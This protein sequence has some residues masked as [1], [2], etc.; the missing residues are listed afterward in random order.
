MDLTT[1]ATECWSAPSFQRV[2]GRGDIGT[3]PS[4]DDNDLDIGTFAGGSLTDVLALLLLGNGVPGD[5][6]GAKLDPHVGTS[7]CRCRPTLSRRR[8]ARISPRTGSIRAKFSGP[9][10]RAVP[11]SH[12]N[13][14][15]CASAASRPR[16]R[17]PSDKQP[18]VTLSMPMTTGR[19]R[20]CREK[21]HV[22]RA[23][24]A[25]SAFSLACGY[26]Q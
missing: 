6:D 12:R 25:A 1:I 22:W 2:S 20:S 10:H 21:R 3:W 26:S 8:R 11:G 5:H 24:P 23:D 18:G 9:R 14:C 7:N 15:A 16:I 13:C 17:P 4:K 19:V